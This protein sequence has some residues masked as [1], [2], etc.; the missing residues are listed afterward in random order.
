MSTMSDMV[1]TGHMCLLSMW[2]VPDETEELKCEF[3]L[4]WINLNL[5]L[6]RH[7]WLVAITLNSVILWE[8]TFVVWYPVS[9]VLV[10][11]SVPVLQKGLT[12]QRENTEPRGGSPEHQQPPQQQNTSKGPVSSAGLVTQALSKLRLFQCHPWESSGVPLILMSY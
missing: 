2:D 4:N 8:K 1:T 7:M 11:L 6:S 12:E 10:Y 3:Y 5:K 9:K